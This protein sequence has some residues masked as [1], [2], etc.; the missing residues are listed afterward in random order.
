[1][2]TCDSK[3]KSD[4]GRVSNIWRYINFDRQLVQLPTP[5]RATQEALISTPWTERLQ[6]SFPDFSWRRFAKE[7]YFGYPLA[8]KRSRNIIYSKNR[9]KFTYL[10]CLRGV[11]IAARCHDEDP[12]TS[13]RITTET[14]LTHVSSGFSIPLY[15]TIIVTGIEQLNLNEMFLSMV[16]VILRSSSLRISIT[17]SPKTFVPSSTLLF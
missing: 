14:T 17:P 10:S 4:R 7:R 12:T 5:A 1:M 16:T 11:L 3:T 6:P 13:K 9:I 15:K 2:P 8:D